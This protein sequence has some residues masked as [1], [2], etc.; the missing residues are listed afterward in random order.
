MFTSL[1]LA[2]RLLKRKL[3]QV[4][5]PVIEGN[6][7]MR[8]FSESITEHLRMYEGDS[9]APKERFVTIEELEH[10]GLVTTKVQQGFAS[11]DKV[12]GEQV[13][14]IPSSTPPPGT[15]GGGGVRTLRA[16][17]DTEV[18]G[19]K[20]GQGIVF[21]GSAFVP[22]TFPDFVV[23]DATRYD[24]LYY[25]GES[26]RH[27]KQELQWNPVDD[28]LQLAN[29]HSINWLDAAAVPA[30]KEFLNFKEF[31]SGVLG[32]EVGHIIA[33]SFAA[34]TTTSGTYVNKTN[35]VIAHASFD[36]N[37]DYLVIARC[38]AYN[39]TSI[40]TAGNGVRLTYNGTV[41]S[42]GEKLWE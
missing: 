24:M 42:G 6:D 1:T 39:A 12:L 41:V 36:D 14:P 15:G 4:D 25:D 9:G 16:L 11:I 17:D 33:K 3:P 20:G 38:M 40:S 26:W 2:S 23:S 7:E 10:V 27:S 34:Q 19:I 18:A 35:G 31:G 5:V 29:A 21:D 32:S 30:S 28:Y 37:E 13:S 22:K 8:R